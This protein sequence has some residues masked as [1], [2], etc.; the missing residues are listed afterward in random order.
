M[1]KEKKKKRDKI[2]T[3][4]LYLLL[5]EEETTDSADTFRLYIYMYGCISVSHT[6][7]FAAVIT[8]LEAARLDSIRYCLERKGYAPPITKLS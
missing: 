3:I 7:R 2:R 5:D 4:K 1:S 8:L 6:L